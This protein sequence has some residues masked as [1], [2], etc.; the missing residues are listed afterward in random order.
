M[1][2]DGYCSRSLSSRPNGMPRVEL[3]VGADRRLRRSLCRRPAPDLIRVGRSPARTHS[4]T[5]PRRAEMKP[6]AMTYELDAS[7]EAWTRVRGALLG[8][9]G[10]DASRTGS[11]RWS[12]SGQSTAS[13]HFT[14]PTSF[15]GTWVSRNYGDAI[16][17]LLC[18]DGI[19]VSR[20]EF[21]VFPGAATGCGQSWRRRCPCGDVG[22][23]RGPRRRPAGLAARRPLHLRQLRRRQA[24]RARPR[25]RAA[26][27]RGRAS[28]LQPAVPLRRASGSARP[29]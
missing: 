28:R 2:P 3:I 5:L 25:R 16:R 15:I 26:G 17:Q 19:S 27:G 29:T 9:I 22:A 24:E 20:L 8:Q 6:Q 11:S 12:S 10:Q 18:K 14:A 13:A 23:G 21:G 7:A 1:M 4:P